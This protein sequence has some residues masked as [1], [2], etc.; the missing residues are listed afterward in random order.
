[1]NNWTHYWRQATVEDIDLMN[2]SDPLDHSASN[3]FLKRG[4]K[5]GDRVYVISCFDGDFY[6][7]GR[8]IVDQVVDQRTAQRSL[9]YEPW[10]A[11][12]H[13]LTRPGTRTPLRL[14]ATVPMKDVRRLQFISQRGVGYPKFTPKGVP[15][16]Q[17][18]RGVRQITDDTAKLFDRTLGL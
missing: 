9:P 3:M 17:T 12:D 6:V 10:H 15:D 2:L 18:F 7:V 16:P 8:L 4:V 14:N 1:M 13:I 5:Q 11:E